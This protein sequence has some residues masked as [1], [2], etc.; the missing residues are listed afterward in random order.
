MQKEVA[1]KTLGSYLR[2]IDVLCDELKLSYQVERDNKAYAV[3]LFKSYEDAMDVLTG[4]TLHEA[5]FNAITFLG[6]K[7]EQLMEKIISNE[8][9]EECNDQAEMIKNYKEPE[10]T[11]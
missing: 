6:D 9:A 11:F 7:K 3:N 10:Y 8:E 5:M 1:N 2:K 4:D